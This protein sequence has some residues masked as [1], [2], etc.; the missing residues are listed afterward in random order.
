[1]GAGGVLRPGDAAGLGTLT[2]SGNVTMTAG[3]VFRSQLTEGGFAGALSASGTTVDISGAALDISRSSYA[4]VPTTVLTLIDRPA[5][6][7]LVVG[8]FADGTYGSTLVDGL[9]VRNNGLPFVLNYADGLDGTDLVLT[10]DYLKA[11]GLAID[12]GDG[13]D[14]TKRSMVSR[15]SVS[16]N[17]EVSSTAGDV[18]LVQQTSAI[19]PVAV[20]VSVTWAYDPVSQKSTATI[21]FTSS[22]ATYEM[23]NGSFALNDGNY[24]LGYNPYGALDASGE[25]MQAHAADAFY[26][27]FGDGDNDRD[28]DSSDL[29]KFKRAYVGGSAAYNAALDYNGDGLIDNTDYTEFR[30]RLGR[31]LLP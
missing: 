18:F 5:G 12:S 9:A 21:V 25:H 23:A 19:P 16:F 1:V 6:A 4:P 27:F 2:A 15:I 10:R 28:V 30:K 13:S 11:T 31:R 17:G 14:P 7:S 8:T 20:G 26:R 3:S 29:V 22:S 24:R